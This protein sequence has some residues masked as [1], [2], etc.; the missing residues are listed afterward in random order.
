MSDTIYYVGDRPLSEGHPIS[1]SD[2][3][4]NFVD[5][6]FSA[7]IAKQK[8]NLAVELFLILQGQHTQHEKQQSKLK[9]NDKEKHS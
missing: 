6:A 9:I 8:K 3:L 5:G 1:L 7:L 2:A 4:V